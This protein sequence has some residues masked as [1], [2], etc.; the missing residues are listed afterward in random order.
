MKGKL[1]EQWRSQPCSQ[2][3]LS[4]NSVHA[5]HWRTYGNTFLQPVLFLHG[6]P[7]SGVDLSSL[8]FFDPDVHFM[9]MFD[10]RGTG[11]SSP[12]GSIHD[13]TTQHLIKDIESLRLSLGIS[14]W[15]VFGGSWGATLGLLYGQDHPLSCLGIVL[16]G[17]SNSHNLPEPLDA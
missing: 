7:G 8:C 4:V 9:V 12:S 3:M 1:P 11:Q 2:G 15:I 16:R 14:R 10:Q 5:L 17:V 6:G 13:N